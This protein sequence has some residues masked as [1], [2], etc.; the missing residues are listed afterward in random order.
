MHAVRTEEHTGTSYEIYTCVVTVYALCSQPGLRFLPFH[1]L[2]TRRLGSTRRQHGPSA[3]VVRVL[4]R[5]QSRARLVEIVLFA[6]GEPDAL[7][8][9]APVGA[10]RDRFALLYATS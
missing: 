4:D 10:V 2:I 5:D 6:K 9:H 7:Q 3:R 8:I 1:L